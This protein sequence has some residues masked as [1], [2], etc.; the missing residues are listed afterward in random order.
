MKLPPNGQ[1]IEMRQKNRG[2]LCYL[3]VVVVT[4]IHKEKTKRGS[5]AFVGYYFC[6]HEIKTMKVV[7]FYNEQKLKMG[8]TMT[9][10][11]HK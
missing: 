2:E 7:G 11:K 1:C 10:K 6:D 3:W 5:F 8:T 4:N 9:K